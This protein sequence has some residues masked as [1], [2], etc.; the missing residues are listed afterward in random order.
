MTTERDINQT[1]AVTIDFEDIKYIIEKIIGGDN[2]EK[3]WQWCQ[4]QC[5]E[6][7]R[8]FGA[9]DADVTKIIERGELG[10]YVNSGDGD[11]EILFYPCGED[12]DNLV[13]WATGSRELIEIIRGYIL[14]EPP[15]DQLRKVAATLEMALKMINDE[16]ESAGRRIL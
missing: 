9:F 10:L 15:I 7:Y 11:V 13:G 5:E 4:G 12:V 16:I 1:V 3:Y 2:Y 6:H 8:A 14:C